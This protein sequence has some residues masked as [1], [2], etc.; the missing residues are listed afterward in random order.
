MKRLLILCPLVLVAACGKPEERA[1]RKAS[2]DAAAIAAVEAAQ[3]FRPPVQTVRLE[4][5]THQDVEA[6]N[7]YGA[8]CNF[9]GAGDPQSPL[10]IAQSGRAIIKTGGELT[11]LFADIAG[12]KLE[13]GAWEHYT[14]KRNTLTIRRTGQGKGIP[15]GEE[16][17][18]YDS[19]LIVFDEYGRTVLEQTGPL[20]C[21]A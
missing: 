10:V 16:V 2:E 5:I 9:V 14:G 6:N 11:V 3:N 12:Q 18:R 21:G 4:P 8:G 19:R 7:L 15:A 20:D 17:T 1:A 13:M